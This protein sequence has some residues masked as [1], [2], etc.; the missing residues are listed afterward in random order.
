MQLVQDSDCSVYDCEFVS[1]A[2]S[3]N[4]KLVALDKKI[5]TNFNDIAVSLEELKNPSFKLIF[6]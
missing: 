6:A 5:L 3:L 4:T 2:K 1:L